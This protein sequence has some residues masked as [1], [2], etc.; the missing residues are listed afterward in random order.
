MSQSTS[1]ERVD[2]C[3]R[4]A[5]SNGF[6]INDTRREVLVDG[7]GELSENFPIGKEVR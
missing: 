1:Q 6:E 4:Q 5:L 2:D 7:E 3:V